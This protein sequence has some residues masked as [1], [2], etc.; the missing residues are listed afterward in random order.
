MDEELAR[1]YME[2]K[3]AGEKVE[4]ASRETLAGAGEST[5]YSYCYALNDSGVRHHLEETISFDLSLMHVEHLYSKVQL[6]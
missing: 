6:N 4:P 5:R 1:S 2:R 3:K